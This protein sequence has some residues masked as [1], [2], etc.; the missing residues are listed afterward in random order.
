[1]R[2]GASDNVKL[3]SV[4]PD[5]EILKTLNWL[6]A[7][8]EN[9][10]LLVKT[11]RNGETFYRKYSDGFIIQGGY[12]ANRD[13]LGEGA[14]HTVTL[15]TSFTNTK[16][17]VLRSAYNA[18]VGGD[19]MYYTSAKSQKTTSFVA[20]NDSSRYYAGTYWMAFGY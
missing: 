8:S 9:A 4:V 17:K 19:C 13:T 12:F 2:G 20:W 7:R 16:Y 3:S 11:Y 6:K 18:K 15:P 5:A 10:A 14:E 1:M